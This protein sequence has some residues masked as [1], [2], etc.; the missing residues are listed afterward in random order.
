MPEIIIICA[1]ARSNRVIGKNHK[2]PW[3]IPEDIARFKQVTQGY[4][5]IMGRTTW[6]KDLERH[7]LPNR[8]NIIV[9]SQTLTSTQPQ[10]IFVRSIPEALEQVVTEEKAFVVGGAQIYAQ[11]LD[12]ADTLDLTLVEGTPEGD[13]VFPPYEHL[14]G[15]QFERVAQEI[16]PTFSFETYRR[17]QTPKTQ[18]TKQKVSDCLPPLHEEK[19]S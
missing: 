12:R 3:V 9:S 7:P 11:F 13:T 17:I 19:E 8:R 15:S 18:L 16:Y 10:V 4:P 2:V 6:E 14:L 1:L 5:V